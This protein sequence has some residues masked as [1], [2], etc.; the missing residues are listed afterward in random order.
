MSLQVALKVS[1]VPGEVIPDI[2]EPTETPSEVEAPIIDAPIPVEPDGG[3]GDG[4]TPLP[5]PGQ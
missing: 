4:A 2:E 1:N 3:I 5:A